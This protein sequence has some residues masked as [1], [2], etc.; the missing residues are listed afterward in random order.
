[1]AVL[2]HSPLILAS[3]ST[4]RQQM[5]KSVGL[6]FSV[7]PSGVDEEAVQR[8]V[9][10]L[11]I[12]EQALAL[13]TAKAVAVGAR[14]PD[15][16]TIG[17]D[18][19]CAL[20]PRIFH[21][22]GSYKAAEAQLAALAGQ[23]HHQHCGT[24]LVRGTEIIFATHATASLT[25]RALTPADIRAYVLADAPLNS[26][27]AYKFEALGRH[28]FASVDGDQDVIKGL[29]LLPLVAALHAQAVIALA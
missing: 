21:K 23:T 5:L 17:A 15:S 20:G 7:E 12:A 13:A 18:Q 25:M 8:T 28:L 9:S 22:P 19:I 11:P 4:I 27:G 2:H 29:A 24:V 6:T 3:G 14:N 26:C 16:Y 1:M 10:H